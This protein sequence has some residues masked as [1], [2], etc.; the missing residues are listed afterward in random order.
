MRLLLNKKIYTIPILEHVPSTRKIYQ[1]EK[2]LQEHYNGIE[3]YLKSH[4]KKKKKK[5]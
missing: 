1:H 2:K 3:A 5:A 4:K